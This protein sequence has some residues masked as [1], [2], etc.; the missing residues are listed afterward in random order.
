MPTKKGTGKAQTPEKAKRII[1]IKRKTSVVVTPVE[2][3]KLPKIFPKKQAPRS[4][5]YSFIGTDNKEYSL[6]PMQFKFADAMMG[7]DKSG[8]QA[9][10][11][12]GYNVYDEKGKL[13]KHL[14]WSI[15]TENLSKPAILEYLRTQLQSVKMT[16][17]SMMLEMSFLAFQRFDLKTKAK[18]IDMFWKMIGEYAPEKHEHKLDAEIAEALNKVA[19]LVK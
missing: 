2:K 14:V 4:K 10:I 19:S 11:E 3:I 12:A 15:S 9:V 13:N 1:K 8:F 18:A 16:K 5:V 7:L 17:D 6:T